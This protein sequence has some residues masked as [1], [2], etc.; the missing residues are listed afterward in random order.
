MKKTFLV[1]GAG[2]GGLAAALAM[3]RRGFRVDVFEQATAL[4]E[5]GAGVQLGPNVTRVLAH[6]GVL[7]AVAQTACAPSAVCAVRSQTGQ[8]LASFDLRRAAWRYGSPHLTVRRADL[9]SALFEAAENAGVQVHFDHALAYT[10]NPAGAAVDVNS[11]LSGHGADGLVAADGIWSQWR[12]AVGGARGECGVSGGAA[13]G[14]LASEPHAVAASMPIATGHWAWRALIPLAD[15]PVHPA[16]QSSQVCAWLGARHHVVTYPV[17]SGRFLNVAAF[18]QG[19]WGAQDLRQWG[20]AATVGELLADMGPVCAPLI[21]LLGASQSLTR[22]PV[23]ARPPLTAACDMAFE[24]LALLGDAAH[25]M[26]PYV[27]QGAGMAIEDACVLAQTLADPGLSVV[28][29]FG[30]YAQ[31]RWRRNARVQAHSERNGRIFHARGLVA[32]ARNTA[33]GWAPRLM[34]APWIYAYDATKPKEL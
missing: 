20:Q 17:C 4:S 26:R 34:D 25:P 32:W 11:C 9:Q 33:L 13:L 10:P 19:Q 14:P 18:T 3:A 8:K 22:W 7:D 15:V 31:L 21:E 1:V 29:A 24:T 6:W 5:W 27:A 16:L 12:L 28:Q 30:R 2:I 23:F